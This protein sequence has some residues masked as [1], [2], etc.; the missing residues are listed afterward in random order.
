MKHPHEKDS[1]APAYPHEKKLKKQAKRQRHLEK[2]I[3]EQSAD[4]LTCATEAADAFVGVCER[5]LE[6]LEV[7]LAYLEIAQ[8][9]WAEHPQLAL[10]LKR[11]LG[12]LRLALEAQHQSLKHIKQD[13]E[14]LATDPAPHIH[15]D[16]AER[17]H[18]L[19]RERLNGPHSRSAAR[20]APP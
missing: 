19:I 8:E 10:P 11:S 7:D 16:P 1:H 5:S 18:P 2:E 15:L 20:A 3:V 12:Q 6:E 9:I 4:V 17:Y 14:R 13:L